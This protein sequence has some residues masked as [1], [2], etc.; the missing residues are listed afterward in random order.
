MPLRCRLVALLLLLLPW[1]LLLRCVS[2]LIPL[3]KVAMVATHVLT[4]RLVLV[5]DVMLI[6][7][8]LVARR[9]GVVG[10]VVLACCL[11]AKVRLTSSARLPAR[12]CVVSGALRPEGGP[13][14]AAARARRRCRVG[15]F[16]VSTPRLVLPRITTALQVRGPIE[17][18]TRCLQEHGACWLARAIALFGYLLCAALR[19]PVRVVA[20]PPSG[21]WRTRIT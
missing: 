18:F 16:A 3:L 14:A 9:V 21:Q 15:P 11:C 6:G 12:V 7:R 1:L 17:Q 19:R 2:L 8:R 20:A 5:V 13:L 4:R 10:G